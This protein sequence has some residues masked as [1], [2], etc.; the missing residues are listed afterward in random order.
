MEIS[1]I[2]LKLFLAI[3]LGALMGLARDGSWMKR[4]DRKE[5]DAGSKQAKEKF[6]FI[7][8]SKP[9]AG[10]GGVRTYIL[11]SMLGAIVG[12]SYAYEVYPLT[13][14]ITAGFVMF[15]LISFVL[16]YFD[17]NT[18]GLT[19][20]IS[21]IL[22]FTLAVLLF[23]TDLPMKF[24]AMIAVI[25]AIII[26]MRNQMHNLIS[27]FS[28][29][30]ITD[31]MKFVLFALVILPFMPNEIYGL[32]D[33]PAIGELAEKLFSPEFLQATEVFNPY[34]LWFI[35]ALVLGI[36]YVGYFAI[37]ALGH[38]KGLYVV[39]FLGGIIS[40]TAVTETMARSSRTTK[41]FLLKGQFLTTA[42]FANFTSY[43]RMLILVITLNFTLGFVALIPLV[44]MSVSMIFSVFVLDWLEHRK[45]P[46]TKG[47]KADLKDAADAIG[48][49]IQTPFALTPAIA[50]ASMFLGVQ[51]ISAIAIEFFGNV[52]F[53][54]ASMIAAI[55]GMDAVTINTSALAGSEITYQFGMAVLVI[56]SCVNLIG[57][58]ALSTISG[59]MYFRTRLANI[60][61]ITMVAGII[62][63]MYVL[64]V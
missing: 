2:L 38:K 25:D 10:L 41:N 4:E 17:K 59:D 52:G 40:S 21:L 20:E 58:L 64:F 55:P 34:E 42:V 36:N 63:M 24:I 35:V 18:F 54:V 9:A 26:S 13:W 6:S 45:H 53:M 46:A 27:K 32:A 48:G 11:I 19:T 23:S 49:S 30:E 1:T 37:R 15:I 51:I 14:I 29:K 3:S 57:K 28:N 47:S 50:F 12:L 60:F 22:N 33:I 16:N 7:H 43:I 39:G 44:V 5:I 31:T 56:S 62:S 8:S 61:I